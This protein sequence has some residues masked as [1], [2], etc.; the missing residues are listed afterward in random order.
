MRYVA[1]DMKRADCVFCSHF[2]GDHDIESLILVRGTHAFVVMNL[3]PYNSGHVM[4][5]PNEHVASPEE[6]PEIALLEMAILRNRLLHALRSALSPAG[7]NVGI[8]LGD[9]AGAGIAMH[10]HEH[11]VPR[12]VGDA[13]FMPIVGGTKVLPELLPATYAKVR[14]ELERNPGMIEVPC[15]FLGMNGKEVLLADAEKLPCTAV[16]AG[17]PI[18]RALSNDAIGRGL[19]DFEIVGWG[20]T[21]ERHGGAPIVVHRVFSRPEQRVESNWTWLPLDQALSGSDGLLLDQAMSMVRFPNSDL[22]STD[23]NGT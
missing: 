13:N 12:W 8:N 5:V 18:W 14:A 3:Y 1:G 19:C 23:A 22:T 6:L 11:I 16:T 15:V 7:F 21:A 2:A 9:A 17:T 4:I 20:G 10:L